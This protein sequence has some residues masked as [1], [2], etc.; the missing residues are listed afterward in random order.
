MTM[1]GGY[2]WR[3]WSAGVPGAGWRSP[4][5]A[6]HGRGPEHGPCCAHAYEP[7]WAGARSHGSGHCRSETTTEGE[8]T[9]LKDEAEGLKHY[10]EGIERRISE[11]QKIAE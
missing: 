3:H 6:H 10:L 7:E 5:W 9:F 1:C 8:L 4:G 11:L 2:R